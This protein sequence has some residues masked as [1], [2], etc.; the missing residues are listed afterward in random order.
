MNYSRNVLEKEY[1]NLGS[2]SKESTSLDGRI[3]NK[4]KEAEHIKKTLKCD[5]SKSYG[6]F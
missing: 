3:Q 2:R 5:Q 6:L 4:S 1:I